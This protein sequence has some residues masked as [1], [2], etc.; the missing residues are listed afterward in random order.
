MRSE[1]GPVIL[2]LKEV[3][4]AGPRAPGPAGRP[5]FT[6]VFEG[7][8]APVLPQRIYRLEHPAWEG[9]DLF[10]VPVGASEVGIC[11]EAVFN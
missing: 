2:E 7:P 5:G 3:S 11:Y 6:L 1:G 9:L 4:V 8:P 10:L